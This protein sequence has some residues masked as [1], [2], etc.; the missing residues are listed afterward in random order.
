MKVDHRDGTHSANC[1]ADSAETVEFLRAVLDEVVDMPTWGSDVQKTV[2]APQLLFIVQVV[3]K[4]VDA[5]VVVQRQTGAVV[6]TV[7]D[8][9]WKC[10]S[11][12]KFWTSC[13]HPCCGLG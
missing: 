11:K 2:E 12:K 8:T 9:F 7:Q 5:P 6:Q 10:R 3:D 1:A 4:V 13:R